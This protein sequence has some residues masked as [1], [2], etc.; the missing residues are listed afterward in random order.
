MRLQNILTDWNTRH[1]A[2]Q[3]SL[4]K[5]IYMLD[6]KYTEANLMFKHLKGRDRLLGRYLKDACDKGNF[7]LL[8][9]HMTLT[10]S[11]VWGEMIP[12]EEPE[13]A[14][15][16]SSI[17]WPDGK[18]LLDQG[19]VDS[20]EV[21]HPQYDSREPDRVTPEETG[22]QG[23]DEAHFY[24]DAVSVGSLWLFTKHVASNLL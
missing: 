2:G 17:I 7:V 18:L 21:I 24:R 12:E 9:A 23:I 16:L 14:L 19:N 4:N 10:A 13:E 15:E 5:L 11:N 8:L 20:D 1:E 22:N 3:P 6:H